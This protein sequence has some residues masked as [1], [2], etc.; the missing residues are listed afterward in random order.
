MGATLKRIMLVVVFLIG[1][2]IPWTDG[3]SVTNE[4][5]REEGFKTEIHV[6]GFSE[7]FLRLPTTV[8]NLV[9]HFLVLPKT[10]FSTVLRF[11]T[12]AAITIEDVGGN[13]TAAIIGLIN[14]AGMLVVDELVA[15]GVLEGKTIENVLDFVQK[16]TLKVIEIVWDV[17]IKM[18][19][20][21][22]GNLEAI[23][24][25]LSGI[26]GIFIKLA[27]LPVIRN[28]IEII[29]PFKHLIKLIIE[30]QINT[31]RTFVSG[32]LVKH[33][34]FF[35]PILD[36]LSSRVLILSNFLHAF[37]NGDLQQCRGYNHKT[38]SPTGDLQ[39]QLNMWIE[40]VKVIVLR[41]L[42][43]VNLADS[44]QVKI[45]GSSSSESVSEVSESTDASAP[46][47]TVEWSTEAN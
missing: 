19:A 24:K 6:N 13:S 1:I 42:G 14:E 16:L 43:L 39:W 34:D 9:K 30:T 41:I 47:G 20:F 45:N 23:F 26:R 29:K 33:E 3:H 36:G 40:Q 18:S 7:S 17:V 31:L 44:V 21:I 27:K 38:S 32:E 25:S 12:N 22:M 10:I 5:N 11:V 28:I 37:V 35:K 4:H 15:I 2:S 8:L 46:F